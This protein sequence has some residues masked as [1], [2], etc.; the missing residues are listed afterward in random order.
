VNLKSVF[1]VN[2]VVSMLYG[3]SLLVVP[4]PYMAM[5][6]VTLDSGGAALTQLFGGSLITIA[7]IVWFARDAE[8]STTR[9][10]I[11]QALCWGNALG[12][13]VCAL[14]TLRGAFGPLAWSAVVVYAV[15]SGIYGWFLYGKAAATQPAA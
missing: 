7:L 1:Q 2:A 5:Y 6:G 4:I 14:G 9:T 10:A 12:T 11:V 8:A 15:F 13:L 3:I